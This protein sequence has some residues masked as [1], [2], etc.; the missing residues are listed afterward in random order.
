MIKC[1]Y[2][3]LYF[4]LFYYFSKT[5]S[6][7]IFP[8]KTGSRYLPVESFC[9]PLKA[10]SN[11]GRSSPKEEKKED[12]PFTEQPGINYNLH[13][14]KPRR[15]DSSREAR[16]GRTRGIFNPAN[17]QTAS[18]YFY[19]NLRRQILLS[20]SSPTSINDSPSNSK[21]YYLYTLKSD[22]YL[23]LI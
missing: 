18:Q 9:H 7:T 2:P 6:V 3:P 23:P 4:L 1:K 17:I 22:Y 15:G 11:C 13:I 12:K 14:E 20:A 5:C 16:R 8:H 21:I 10:T 19:I